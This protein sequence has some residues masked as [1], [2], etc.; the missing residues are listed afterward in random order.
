M[1]DLKQLKDQGRLFLKNNQVDKALRIFSRIL[2]ENPDD[3]DAMLILGDS[4]LL[5]NEKAA[6]LNLYQRASQICPERRDIRRR[7]VLFQTSDHL[8]GEAAHSLPTEPRAVAELIQRQTGNVALVSEEDVVKANKLLEEY[9][10]SPTP[11]QAVA[12]HFDEI[13][14]LLPALIELNVRQA[15]ADGKNDL[16]EALQDMLANVLLQIDLT[17]SAPEK[18]PVN[19]I[20]KKPHEKQVLLVGMDSYDAPLRKQLIAQALADRGVEVMELPD[21]NTG[22]TWGT[23]EIMIAHNPHGSQ[24]FGRLIG[25][26]AAAGLATILDLDMNFEKLPVSHPDYEQLGLKTANDIRTYRAS[27]MLANQVCVKS[28]QYE[29]ILREDG[30][31]TQVIPDSWNQENLLWHKPAPQRSTFNIGIYVMPGQIEDVKQIRRSVLHVIREFPNTRL[32]INGD[33]DVFRMFDSLPDS[34]RVFL[35]S[36]E[37]EDYPYLLAQSDI[38]LFPLQNNEFN[39]QRSDSNVMDAGIRRIPWIGSPTRPHTDWGSGGLV[40]FSNEDWYTHMVSLIHDMEL[41]KKLGIAG[42]QKALKRENQMIGNLWVSAIEQVLAGV[43]PT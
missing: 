42:F 15:R 35:P 33:L 23:C 43:Q 40:V 27:L 2:R 22:D 21:E 30:F 9:L 36:V 1:T 8:L 19:K 17:D 6:A 34:K 18:H 29:E 16:A 39:N 13:D 5:V 7:V 25:A 11:S 32:V 20:S 38:L 3:I 12:Q 31:P 14:Q 24:E 37:D 28:A 10:R 26:R 4:Y 41:R